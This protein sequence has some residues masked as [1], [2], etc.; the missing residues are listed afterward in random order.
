MLNIFLSI[1]FLL[2][3][4]IILWTSISYLSTRNIE[5]PEFLLLAK[6]SDFEIREFSPYIIAYIDTISS[7]NQASTTGFRI[8][9][10]YIF[11]NNISSQ[12]IKM[13]SPVIQDTLKNASEKIKMTAP[14]IQEK[15]ENSYR[16]AFVMPSKYTLST[17]PKPVDPRVKIMKVEKEIRAVYTFKGWATENRVNS[18]IDK[19]TKALNENKLF[20]TE[21]KLAQYDPPYTPPYM[22]KN[23]LHAIL[24][25]YDVDIS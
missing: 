16:V 21:I 24:E 7:F 13:T 22:R 18:K 20:F 23:E 12:K 5:E 10:D 14:V 3:L 6:Y 1:T 11:G 9:A 17:L 2:S 8:L 4:L 25:N 15:K 19:F